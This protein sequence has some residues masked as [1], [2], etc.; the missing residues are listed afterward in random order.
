MGPS[1]TVT[2]L[3]SRRRLRLASGLVAAA[4]VVVGAVL[5]APHL[6]S[7]SSSSATESGSGVAGPAR[8]P[9]SNQISQPGRNTGKSAG[10]SKSLA[11][12]AFPSR[13]TPDGRVLVRPHHFSADARAVQRQ[14][15]RDGVAA[16][17]SLRTVRCAD[18]PPGGEGLA[19]EYR[20]APAALVFHP[21]QQGSQVVDLYACGT[22]T[23]LRSAT[24]PVP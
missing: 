22:S 2:P 12:H 13:L 9:G 3:V 14:L 1:A 8:S 5:A 19:V 21:A 23:P 6:S 7:S 24:L 15:R 18:V 4:A 20:H 16:F 10:P 17:D 11:P